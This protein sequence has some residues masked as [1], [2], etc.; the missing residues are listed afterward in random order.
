VYN[1]SNRTALGVAV[2]NLEK[3]IRIQGWLE[4]SVPIF[5]LSR[6]VLT[7]YIEYLI[8][9]VRKYT[10]GYTKIQGLFISILTLKFVSR[11]LASTIATRD[12]ATGTSMSET[13][14]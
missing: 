9:R 11:I 14:Y 5:P 6:Q 4:I 2:D 7:K 3:Q 8:A 12:L 10:L 13:L 1:E